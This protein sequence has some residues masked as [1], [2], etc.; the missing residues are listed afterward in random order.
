[1]GVYTKYLVIN[2]YIVKYYGKNLMITSIRLL[3]TG[4]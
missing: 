3:K 1:M 2:K 4:L